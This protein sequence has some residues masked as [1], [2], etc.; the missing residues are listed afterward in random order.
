DKG[1]DEPVSTVNSSESEEKTTGSS[2]TGEEDDKESGDCKEDVSCNPVSQ[3][4]SLD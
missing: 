2:E 1:F 3:S 4:R